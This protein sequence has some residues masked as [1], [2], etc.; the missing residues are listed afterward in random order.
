MHFIYSII[1]F[2]QVLN[3][4]VINSADIR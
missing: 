2:T 1:K 4:T 3:S